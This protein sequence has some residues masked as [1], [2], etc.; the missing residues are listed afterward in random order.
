MNSDH[1]DPIWTNIGGL[2]AIGVVIGS[3]AAYLPPVAAALSIVWT[4]MRIYD[5]IRHW[6]RD[7]DRNGKM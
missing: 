7:Q 5:L 3:L 4:L 6:I 1:M 2:T